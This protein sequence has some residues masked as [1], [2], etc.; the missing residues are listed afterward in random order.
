MLHH[1][2]LIPF[3]I[4]DMNYWYDSCKMFFKRL[5][6]LLLSML[7]QCVPDLDKKNKK[8]LN[9]T[10]LY[11]PSW[12]SFGTQRLKGLF[13]QAPVWTDLWWRNQRTYGS[14]LMCS[15]GHVLMWSCAHVV[16]CSCGHVVMWS[17]GHVLM[18][19]C[20]RPQD[21]NAI[22]QTPKRGKRKVILLVVL[23]VLLFSGKFNLWGC[24]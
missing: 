15:C 18:W 22:A 6:N 4:I 19:S 23:N 21:E 1:V 3:C 9:W 12:F 2:C 7:P 10:P 11:F 20:G 8:T 14:V 24:W 13:L 17:C 16:M 5:N